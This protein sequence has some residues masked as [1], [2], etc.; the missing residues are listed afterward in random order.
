MLHLPGGVALACQQGPA[1]P[2]DPGVH[3][4][5]GVAGVVLI[6][7]DLVAQGA[8]HIPVEDAGHRLP[9]QGQVHLEAAVLFQ[10]REVQAGHRDLGVARL[11][12]GLAQQ[13]DVVG[14]AAAATG[15]GDEQGGVVQVVLA[16]V[17]RVDELADDQQRRVAGVVVDVFQAQLGHRAAAVAQDLAL[18]ALVFQRIFEQPE[19]GDCHVGDED[20]VGLLHLLGEFGVM[21]F[22]SCPP[23]FSGRRQA[24]APVPP[25]PPP[26]FPAPVRPA[27]PAPRTGCAAGCSPRPG[28]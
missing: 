16:A 26:V 6:R 4:A 18:V 12:Q 17:Q 5:V 3:Q 9:Q 27:R 23:I 1:D 20:G 25:W 22:H 14:S 8:Q 2:A 13:V 24:G 10:A 19:L 21:V 15:L 11:D 28:W 7:G